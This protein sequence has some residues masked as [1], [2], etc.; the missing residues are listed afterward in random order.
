MDVGFN[1]HTPTRKWQLH[2]TVLCVA[3]TV[4]ATQPAYAADFYLAR[5]IG[6]EYLPE[7]EPAAPK[8]APETNGQRPAPEL[9]GLGS[10]E[11]TREPSKEG[12]STWSKVLIGAVVVGAIAALGSNGGGG[13]SA[14]A[15]DTGGAGSGGSD[16]GGGGGSGDIDIGIGIGSGG[17][18]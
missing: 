16:G 8:T 7:E 4:I 15:T 9:P 12:M 2:A 6:Q 1:R 18:G 10:R 3:L 17:G 14:P 5:A 11:E 13:S